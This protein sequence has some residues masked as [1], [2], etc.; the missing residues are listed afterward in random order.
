VCQLN[1]IGGSAA[2]SSPDRPEDPGSACGCL[3][4]YLARYRYFGGPE[5]TARV[6]QGYEIGRPSELHLTSKDRGDEIE[7]RVGGRVIP[8]ARGEPI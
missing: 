6:D 8:V 3:A 5:V 4:G 7:V 2:G 1:S